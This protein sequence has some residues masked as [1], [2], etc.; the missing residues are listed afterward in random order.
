MQPLH[1]A[2]VTSSA[3]PGR[4]FPMESTSFSEGYPSPFA[5]APPVLSQ[6]VLGKLKPVQG[7]S[8]RPVESSESHKAYGPIDENLSRLLISDERPGEASSQLEGG[9]D[10][11]APGTKSRQS[12][13]KSLDVKVSYGKHAK[14][15]KGAGQLSRSQ[16]SS[17]IDVARNVDGH[18]AELRLH[19]ISQPS[20]EESSVRDV[21]GALMP[22]FPSPA[23]SHQEILP[24]SLPGYPKSFPIQSGT[25]EPVSAGPYQSL[26]VSIPQAG[27]GIDSTSSSMLDRQMLLP[28][29]AGMPSAPSGSLPPPI[30]EHGSVSMGPSFRNRPVDTVLLPVTV[31]QPMYFYYPPIFVMPTGTDGVF[32]GDAMGGLHSNGSMDFGTDVQGSQSRPRTIPQVSLSFQGSEVGI[33]CSCLFF[34]CSSALYLLKSSWVW[35]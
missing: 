29:S 2:P 21:H 28:I 12:R 3:S 5:V 24:T 1:R 22:L 15:T 25:L 6:F 30:I 16:S 34:S 8:V 10:Y 13:P 7:G 23:N 17:D 35:L 14:G 4:S 33:V 32:R 20:L 27:A 18:A 11:L 19:R 31:P 9:G 26:Q